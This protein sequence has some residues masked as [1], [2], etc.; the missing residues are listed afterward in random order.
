M[1][2]LDVVKD[3]A[4]TLRQTTS[5]LLDRR[6]VLLADGSQ[7]PLLEQL[8]QKL[9]GMEWVS[10]AAVR[11]R[12]EG[13]TLRG[14]AFV[15]PVSDD[16]LTHNIDQAARALTDHHWRIHEVIVTVAPPP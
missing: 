12:E 3:G 9:C 8:E 7:D 13:H 14:E 11:L 10:T 16:N 5:D 15:V 2:A 6:P 4:A 1:I